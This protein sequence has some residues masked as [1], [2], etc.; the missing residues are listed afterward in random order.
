MP[1]SRVPQIPLARLV[2]AVLFAASVAA[3]FTSAAAAAPMRPGLWEL[4]MTAVVDGEPQTVP[5]GR[6]CVSQKDIDDGQKTLPR[7][8]GACRLSN[9]QRTADRA[10][11][12]LECRKDTVVTRGRAEIT[13][14]AE[15]YDGKVDMLITGKSEVGFPMTMTLKATRIGECTK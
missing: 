9:V 13:F 1:A 5:A 12:D 2:P 11:Y 6:Q 10:T 15:R 7:P 14:A 8:D 4:A 3:L